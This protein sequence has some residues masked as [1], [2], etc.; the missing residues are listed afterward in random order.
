LLLLRT[1][2]GAAHISA[3][4]LV[5]ALGHEA[6]GSRGGRALGMLGAGLTLGVATGAALG[7]LI[8][9]G[10][11]AATL[12]LAS[13]CLGVA[14]LLAR[15]CLPADGP[16][17]DRPGIGAI[18]AAVARERGLLLP[19][20][21][22][23][24]ERFTVG[25]FTTGFP[26]LL[27]G[28]HGVERWRIGALLAAFLYPFALL[29]YP[30]GKLA[31]RRSP[32]LL[33][34]VGSLLYGLG[35]LLVGVVPP[36]WLWLLMPVLGIASA[37]MFVPSLVL[38]IAAAPAVGRST[39]VAAFNAAGSLGFLLG[40]LVCGALVALRE[41]PADGHALAFAVAGAS[42]ILC[43]VMLVPRLRSGAWR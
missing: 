37:V 41:Q 7:G 11:P 38:T 36:A 4:S 40:P 20:W 32:V 10:H 27:A 12:E 17:R 34:A 42:E 24:V 19:L 13:G 15:C 28:V 18:A 6:A 26:L 25:F 2:E 14:A 8:G 39:A 43:A 31:E 22:A 23:F 16:A 1:A 3:L 33:C 9:R 35:T 5:L 30:C 29:S 21:L